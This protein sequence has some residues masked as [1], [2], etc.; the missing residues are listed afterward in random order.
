MHTT[1]GTLDHPYRLYHTHTFYSGQ[2][3]RH[4]DRWCLGGGQWWVV[5]CMVS[6]SGQTGSL[7]CVCFSSF[8]LHTHRPGDSPP[9]PMPVY[10]PVAVSLSPSC[11]SPLLLLGWAGSGEQHT[12]TTYHPLHTMRSPTSL[13]LAP[14][15]HPL[16]CLAHP[17]LGRMDDSRRLEWDVLW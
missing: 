11:P 10:Q 14:S 13:L 12:H 9:L 8:H 16:P 4:V 2:V 17:S 7:R 6:F 15:P 1:H 3:D 5:V